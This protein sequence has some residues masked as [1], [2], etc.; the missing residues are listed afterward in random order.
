MSECLVL[1][2]LSDLR[3]ESKRDDPGVVAHPPDRGEDGGLLDGGGQLPPREMGEEL[4]CGEETQMFCPN[5]SKE[6]PTIEAI[7]LHLN[8]QSTCWPHEER[9][10]QFPVPPGLQ[11]SQ[12]SKPSTT[13]GY[14]H[15]HSG[16]VFGVGKNLFDRLQDDQY[17]Y[18]REINTYYPF[19]DEGE[20]EL[21]KF[22]VENL[23][24]AQIDKFLKLKW[25]HTRAKPSFT[26]KEQLLDWTD[27]LPSFVPWKVSNLE[28]TGY[29]TTYPVQLIWRDA[30]EVVKQLFSDPVFAN[31]ITFQPHVVNT[32]SQREYG[33]YMSANMTWK[34]QDYLPVGATQVPIILGSD[35]TPVTR[36][37]GGLEMHPLFITIGNIDS[38]VRSKA[39]LRAWRCIAYMPVSKFRVHSDYQ[40]IL[41][42]R[43]W[44][45]CVDLV[46]ANLKVA[47][48]D[49]CFMPDPSR[50]IR[51]VFTPLIAHVCDLPEAS[52]IAAID[53]W[54]LDKFQKAAKAAHLSGVHMPYWLDWSFS[55]PSVF[56][57]GEF[58]ADHPLKWIK[59]IVGKTKLDTRFI[60]QHKRVGTHHFTK[61]ITHVNQMTGHE[62]RDIQRT[63]VASI[64]GAAP[65]RFVRA[66]RA[67]IDFFYYAQNS[68]MVQALSDFHAFK[69][70]I[71]EAEARRGKKGAKEDFFIP[72]L[73][74]LQSF[75]GTI[76]RL[77]DMTERLLIT[78]CKDLFARTSRRVNDFTEQCVQIL[79]RQESMELFNLY[80]LITSHGA[81]L[82]NAINLED[83]EVTTVNPALSWISRILPDEAYSVHGPRRVRNHFHKG[84]LSGDAL[85]AFHL[86]STP[87]LK[88]LSPV[89][90]LTKYALIDFD[91]AVSQFIQ[92]SSLSSGKN[93]RWDHRHGRF[94][95][96]NKFRLQ[97]HSAFQP[98]VIMPSRVIQ[99]Y[100]PSDLFPLG[101]CDTVLSDPL[102]IVPRSIDMPVARRS[103]QIYCPLLY[104]QY[105]DFIANPNDRPKLAMWTVEQSYV[106]D[107][108]G[109]RYRRGG[110]VLLTDVT[111]AV[112]LIPEYGEKVNKDISATTCLE[113]YDRFFLNNFADK[114]SYHT[115]STEFA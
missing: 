84:I 80:A 6:F 77:A 19:H 46:C 82:V 95:A 36:I 15:P 114:E 64:S 9:P 110:A 54:D 113:S 103:E 44:H 86:T 35:K 87:D 78:H 23:T 55:C 72:K 91:H 49:G 71:V 111:H 98:R 11:G 88:S 40:T 61:G 50:H 34:I 108:H 41:Q 47:A 53:P 104:I 58:F 75:R 62:H 83:E 65:P 85:T 18:R 66:I 22:L 5:C 105:F 67:L 24:Q 106:V 42:A 92:C 2:E 32:G 12:S 27:A 63:I 52:M 26:S 21:A 25:F 33:D 16:Y 81:S 20:W 3:L 94:Y 89:D 97:L 1:G 37:T 51:Y 93:T 10:H 101:N 109:K 96:W 68:S 56:L 102:L 99:S 8:S 79:N 17:N 100:P 14:C 48:S 29:K 45:K 38:E 60:T 107:Q 69:D 30:L 59:E 112:E 4:T 43:L 76:E 90:I 74:S 31:H 70:A 7:T 39:T 28:F 73:E 115:F 13:T 57:P